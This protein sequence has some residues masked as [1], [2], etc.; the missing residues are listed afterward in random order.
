M[1]EKEAL[2][3][4]GGA[5]W[6]FDCNLEHL[7][8][9]TKYIPK[10]VSIFDAGCGSGILD[11]ALAFLGY[12][13]RGGDLKTNFDILKDKLDRQYDAVINIA[14]IEHQTNLGLFVARLKDMVR[15]GG[16]IYIATPNPTHLLNR[17]RFLFGGPPMGNLKEWFNSDNFTGHVREYTLAELKQMFEWAG[18]KIIEAKNKQVI[19]PKLNFKSFRNI[20]VNLFRFLAYFIPG[21]GDANVILGKK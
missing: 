13:V 21:T 11:M 17:I 16:Y 1:I 12:D 4:A 9:I 19:K 10:N 15:D 14:V 6:D 18:I 3:K 2:K 8:I 7:N 5:G 20:Y